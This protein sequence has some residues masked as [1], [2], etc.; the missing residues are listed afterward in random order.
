MGGNGCSCACLSDAPAWPVETGYSQTPGDQRYQD[1]PV[2]S[3][4]SLTANQFD[5]SQWVDMRGANGLQVCGVLENTSGPINISFGAFGSNDGE[6]AVQIGTWNV[7]AIGAWWAL[8]IGAV[9][10]KY[11]RLVVLNGN[12]ITVHGPIWFRT[13]WN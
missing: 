7:S 3:E 4:K 1:I 6:L 13:L 5:M 9:S 2:W 12:I 10:W 8:A 11:V